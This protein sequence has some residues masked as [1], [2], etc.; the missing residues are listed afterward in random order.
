MAGGEVCFA[1]FSRSSDK[2]STPSRVDVPISS[3][4]KCCTSLPALADLGGDDEFRN[5]R[6]SLLEKYDKN[7]YG[8]VSIIIQKE[9]AGVWTDQVTVH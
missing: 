2:L 7:F 1:L 5:D 8:L 6:H 9:V 3:A 4:K